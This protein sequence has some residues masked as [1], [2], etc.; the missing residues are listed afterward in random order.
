MLDSFEY[1]SALVVISPA[2]GEWH[3][4]LG[5]RRVGGFIMNLA[6]PQN[7]ALCLWND[8]QRWQQ[9]GQEMIRGG[10]TTADQRRE[11]AMKVVDAYMDGKPDWQANYN[12]EAPPTIF[13]DRVDVLPSSPSRRP[14]IFVTDGSVEI[15]GLDATPSLPTTMPDVRPNLPKKVKR[16]STPPAEPF[17]L[18]PIEPTKDVTNDLWNTSHEG[19]AYRLLTNFDPAGDKAE[20]YRTAGR[21]WPNEIWMRETA[22]D[23]EG[24]I[25]PGWHS[26]YVKH[27]SILT[28]QDVWAS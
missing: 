11:L 2:L 24:A 25:I 17:T 26:L 5:D 20:Q 4:F 23:A 21:R 14:V 15:D 28:L 7:Y 9:F 8:A 19:V 27:E 10:I 18:A 22:F 12:A 16:R 6:K 13:Y 3:I 1:R